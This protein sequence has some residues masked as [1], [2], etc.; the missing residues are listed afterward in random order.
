ML[1]ISNGI[2]YLSLIFGFLSASQ[3]GLCGQKGPATTR[4]TS[5]WV[6]EKYPL[7]A[8]LLAFVVRQKSLF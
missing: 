8:L 6:P 2:L 1:L 4:F 3:L 5:E 7:R